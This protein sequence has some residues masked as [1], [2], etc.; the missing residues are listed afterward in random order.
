MIEDVRHSLIPPPRHLPSFN[1][2]QSDFPPDRCTDRPR[3]TF[4]LF[5]SYF[6]FFCAS[7]RLRAGLP[8]FPPGLWYSPPLI[9]LC[10]E[11]LSFCFKNYLTRLLPPPPCAHVFSPPP[12]PVFPDSS[13]C[14][15]FCF[16]IPAFQLLRP[17]PSE[18]VL[19]PVFFSPCLSP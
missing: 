10:P 5:A 8:D 1:Q 7:T 12:L 13:L 16:Y 19:I 17:H 9:A 4:R 11:E 6:L 14:A 15:F 18:G 3:R 2:P